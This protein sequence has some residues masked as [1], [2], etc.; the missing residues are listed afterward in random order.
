M[1]ISN[2]LETAEVVGKYNKLILDAKLSDGKIVPVFCSCYDIFN[3]CDIGTTIY[4]SKREEHNFRIE[5]ELELIAVNEQFI[6]AKP[7]RNNDLFEEAFSDGVLKEFSNF[8]DCYR[9][10][11]SDNLP[12][13]DFEL[14]NP[15]GDKGYVFVTNIYQKQGGV[16]VFPSEINFFEFEMFEEMQQLRIQGYKT[17][18]FMIVP[19]TDCH[20]IRFSWKLSPLA[21]G[22]IFEEAKNGINFIGYGCNINKM[23]VT[24]SHSMPILY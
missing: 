7:N 23:S 4:I 10:K 2:T 17:Y 13:L 12:H 9:L 22:K 16:A 15:K 21:A 6:Y 14:S 8:T 24:L 20:D 11:S 19:R 5:Y 3:I 18:V 1:Q